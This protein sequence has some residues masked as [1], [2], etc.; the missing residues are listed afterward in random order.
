M[1]I[2]CNLTVLLQNWYINSSLVESYVKG[3]AK[4]PG[5]Q[6]VR[7]YHFSSKCLGKIF[8][9]KAYWNILWNKTNHLHEVL[10]WN[11][12]VAKNIAVCS[13]AF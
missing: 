13:E 2:Y 6:T 11:A 8:L 4:L 10:S 3:D 12:S 9:I 1:N 5:R 7:G